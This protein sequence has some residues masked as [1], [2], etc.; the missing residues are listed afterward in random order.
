MSTLEPIRLRVVGLEQPAKPSPHRVRA[1]VAGDVAIG[2]EHGEGVR[3]CQRHEHAIER[4][5]VERWQGR[6]GARDTSLERQF[7]QADH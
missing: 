5:A 6:R 2:R 4:V 7:P 3:V 1:W